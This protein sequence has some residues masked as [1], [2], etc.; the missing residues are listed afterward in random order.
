[1][2]HSRKIVI[3]IAAAAVVVA[4]AA[5]MALA[6]ETSRGTRVD[7]AKSRLGRIL[8][9]TA[10]HLAEHAGHPLGR[11]LDAVTRHVLTDGGQHLV[12]GPLDAPGARDAALE[13][14]RDCGFL[15][16]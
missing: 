13:K 3:A 8:V 7:V 2:H 11:G 12:D 14:A 9:E 5:T 1:M 10:Q 16:A 15:G 6:G 4:F